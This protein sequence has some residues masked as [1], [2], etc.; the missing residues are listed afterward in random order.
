[1]CTRA[2]ESPPPPPPGEEGTRRTINP[3]VRH[4]RGNHL[5]AFN[6]QFIN[7]MS[8]K[9]EPFSQPEHFCIFMIK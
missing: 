4:G 6:S 5:Y 3:P 1:M 9:Y 2:L 8:L 7:D